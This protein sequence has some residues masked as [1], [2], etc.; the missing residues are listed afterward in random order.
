MLHVRGIIK[1]RYIRAEVGKMEVICVPKV[2]NTTAVCI[3]KEHYMVNL[4]ERLKKIKV[5]VDAGKYFTINRA[6]QYGKTTTLRALYLYLQ[7][8]YYVVSMDFQT[9]GSAE[10]Q[11]ETIFSRSFAN[12]FLRSLKRNPVNKTEQLNEAMAQLEKSVASQNDFFAL[13]ALFEQLGDICA[14]SDKPIVLMI[15]EVDS[16]LNNQ[17]FLDFLAQLRT[18]YME[19]D[20]YPTFRSVILA[21]VYDVKN[22]RG[23]IRPE[24]EHRYNS[25][26]NIAADFDISM[27][28]S[29]N[30]IAGML[31]EY[32]A[33]YKTGMNVD[34]MA[35]LLFDDTSGYPF[36]VSRLCQLMDEVVCKKETYGSKSAAWTK[37]GFYEAQRLILAEKNMLFESLSEKLVSYP[38]LND[39]LK[40]L[41][42]TGKP[43]VFNYYEPSI[44]VASMF[45]FVKNKNGM[46]VV[47][48]R[49]FET[50]LYNFY[51]SAAD[52]QKKEIYAAS[53]MD[54]N[55][56]IVNGCLNMRLIL[57]KFVVH[58]HDLYGDQNE[59]FLEEEGRKYFLLYLR[60]IING[61]GNYYI[62]AQTRGQKRTDVIVDYRGH[63]YVIEMKIWRGQEYNN[64]GEKQLAGY[65]D[66]YHVNK[67]Y[68]VSFNFNRKKKT[69]IREIVFND[70]VIIEAVV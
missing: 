54:K 53:L 22:L 45:G 65:L 14:V 21:G 32:E 20:I 33:D 58:F 43:I 36:L 48:N 11:T 26:W 38:E 55:Q 52:M 8:E 23:K 31:T 37:E 51:L 19:R 42:F 69:G 3:P 25:P 61:T 63:Q 13:K 67:G 49:I 5:F 62:E 39:M 41:L 44:G 24:D 35:G 40:S 28:F 10:F 46:L 47:A 70:K 64:R 7:G 29:K 34:E 1:S 60:P 59:T 9:F 18:Q 6:R 15:D 30:E 56:F 50:W 57:E 27:S 2:Y 16:A 66:D 4:D 17:V 12:S 68:M